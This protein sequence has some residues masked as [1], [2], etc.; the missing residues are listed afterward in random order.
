MTV[1]YYYDYQFCYYLMYVTNPK[2]MGY[3]T[4]RLLDTVLAIN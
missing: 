3:Q 4:N 2:K 1:A